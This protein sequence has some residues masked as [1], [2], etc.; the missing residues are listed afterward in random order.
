MRLYRI[1]SP[2]KDHTLWKVEVQCYGKAVK[3]T[4]CNLTEALSSVP[5]FGH[6]VHNILKHFLFNRLCVWHSGDVFSHTHTHTMWICIKR[7]DTGAYE[8]APSI[9]DNGCAGHF[10]DL[11]T[12]SYTLPQYQRSLA[13]LSQT[14]QSHSYPFVHCTNKTSCSTNLLCIVAK[15]DRKNTIQIRDVQSNHCAIDMCIAIPKKKTKYLKQ[16]YN[17]TR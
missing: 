15:A 16:Q 10:P 12:A 13:T 7:S 11:H 6:R 17:I 4:K 3:T 2:P 1:I 9:S 14:L 5:S 8:S